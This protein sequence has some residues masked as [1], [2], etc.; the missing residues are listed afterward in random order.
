MNGAYK[1][2]MGFLVE[3]ELQLRDLTYLFVFGNVELAF[4]Y[5]RQM[6]NFDQTNDIKYAYSFM[7]REE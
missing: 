1:V 3:K 2:T 4:M 7:D 6:S 5:Y